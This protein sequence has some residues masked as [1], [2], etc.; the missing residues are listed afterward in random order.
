ME[1]WQQR[2]FSFISSWFSVSSHCRCVAGGFKRIE[3]EKEACVCVERL[4]VFH[5]G[6]CF[7]REEKNILM[8]LYKEDG[9]F[10]SHSPSIHLFMGYFRQWFLFFSSFSVYLLLMR[11]W[12]NFLFSLC[13][14]IGIKISGINLEVKRRSLF[15]NLALLCNKLSSIWT[16]GKQ[17]L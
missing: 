5:F 10:L 4:D 15:P 14:F 8:Y 7:W 13:E 2:L 11:F 17:E 16:L 6:F 12:G 9:N 3:R 1:N